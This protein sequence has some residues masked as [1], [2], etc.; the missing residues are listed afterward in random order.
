MHDTANHIVTVVTDSRNNGNKD[1]STP[2]HNF[3][4]I[5]FQKEYIWYFYSLCVY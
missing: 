1:D 5:E 2:L 4:W 3:S